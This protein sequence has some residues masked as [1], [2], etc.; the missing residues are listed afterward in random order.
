MSGRFEYRVFHE[1]LSTKKEYLQKYF[2][3]VGQK[4][5]K[6][7]YLLSKE[8]TKY[9]IKIRDNKLDV[10]RF[11]CS[12]D[13]FE[14]WEPF[15]KMEFPIESRYINLVFK[16]E[17]LDSGLYLTQ[18][19]L[20]DFINSKESIKLV[21]LTKKRLLFKKDEVLGEFAN[22]D[23]DNKNFHTVALES[24]DLERLKKITKEFGFEKYENIN[25]YK[26]LNKIIY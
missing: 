6:E 15:F 8:I 12:I 20:E 16:K 13:G 10:K 23:V 19:Q 17:I 11:N 4:D 22:I 21:S 24:D 7:V 25:Y 26:F 9:N 3:S 14:Q 18:K 1:N 2:T 5:T